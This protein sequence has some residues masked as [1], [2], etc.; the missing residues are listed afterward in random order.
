MRMT[1]A[2]FPKS[3]EDEEE[4]LLVSRGDWYRLG[5]ILPSGARRGGPCSVELLVRV[6]APCATAAPG[7]LRDVADVLEALIDRGYSTVCQDD[8]WVCC[9]REVAMRERRSECDAVRGILAR[10]TSCGK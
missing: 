1:T 10:A 6:T 9:Q 7:L 8:G 2:R 3:G 4:F 5:T